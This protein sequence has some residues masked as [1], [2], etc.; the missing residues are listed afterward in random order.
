MEIFVKRLIR[1]PPSAL[2]AQP[3]A[4]RVFPESLEVKR[5]PAQW[6]KRQICRSGS[7]RLTSDVLLRGVDGDAI[8]DA[9]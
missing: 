2:P 9:Q 4:T 3:R 6:I 8:R 7:P 1:A 5:T